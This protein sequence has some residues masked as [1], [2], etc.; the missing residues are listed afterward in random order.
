[1]NILEAFAK[2]WWCGTVLLES[3]RHISS[4]KASESD[5]LVA[6]QP[7]AMCSHLFSGAWTWVITVILPHL[8]FS[9]QIRAHKSSCAAYYLFENCWVGALL[10]WWMRLSFGTVIFLSLTPG[11]SLCWQE[12][13]RGG[14]CSLESFL[15]IAEVTAKLFYFLFFGGC[16][17]RQG[18]GRATSSVNWVCAVAFYQRAALYRPGELRRNIISYLASFPRSSSPQSSFSKK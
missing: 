10:K 15:L 8:F 17:R 16:Y 7:C 4:R 13:E 1:M 9:M 18:G 11:L 3:G 5:Q 2:V 6:A 14:Y 12:G